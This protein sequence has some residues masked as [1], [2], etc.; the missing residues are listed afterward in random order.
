MRVSR[1]ISHTSPAANSLALVFWKILRPTC[2][3]GLRV[4]STSS[5]AP[6]CRT[7]ISLTSS[8]T[9][10]QNIWRRYDERH[11]NHRDVPRG[12]S[13]SGQ[14]RTL[15]TGVASTVEAKP[16]AGLYLL[17]SL[18]F[19]LVA[20]GGELFSRRQRALPNQHF[21]PPWQVTTLFNM[22]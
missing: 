3:S 22:H 2:A 6:S 17:P 5:R 8:S 16:I 19:F 4:R 21:V 10:L 20:R 7:S 13:R 9:S 18:V 14:A 1:R 15:S 12:N 11:H